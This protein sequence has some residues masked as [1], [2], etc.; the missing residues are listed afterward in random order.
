MFIDN[1]CGTLKGG[2][3]CF[4]GRSVISTLR[5][6]GGVQC[7]AA[8]QC[9]SSAKLGAFGGENQNMAGNFAAAKKSYS[10]PSHG[11]M[12]QSRCEDP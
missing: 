12:C 10:Q 5:R 3:G 9:L 8:L 2:H 4:A 1:T 6:G 11:W 7:P